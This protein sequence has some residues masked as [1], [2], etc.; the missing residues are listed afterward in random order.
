MPKWEMCSVKGCEGPS[1]LTL[2]EGPRCGSTAGTCALRPLGVLVYHVYHALGLS[3]LGCT[4]SCPPPP[5][6]RELSGSA[7][8]G[9]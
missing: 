8:Q 4:L 1:E 7:I 3:S 5:Q 9:F 2:K 6:R